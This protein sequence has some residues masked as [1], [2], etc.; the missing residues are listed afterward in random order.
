VLRAVSSLTKLTTLYLQCCPNV[1]NEGLQTLSSLTA[2]STIALYGCTNLT[3]E[4]K[5]ALRTAIPNMSIVN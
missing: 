4:G 3:A 2:L 1:T 5:Q